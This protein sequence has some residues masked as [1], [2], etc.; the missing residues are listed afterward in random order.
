MSKRLYNIAI[1]GESGT[2]KTTSLENLDPTKTLIVSPYKADLPFEGWEEDYQPLSIAKGTG[3][4]VKTNNISEIGQILKYVIAKRPEIDTIVIDDLT[5]FQTKVVTST[6]FRSRKQGNEAFAKWQDFAADMKDNLLPEDIKDLDRDL[7]VIHVYH[8][9]KNDSGEQEIKVVGKMLKEKIDL[10]SYYNYVL[11][12][13]VMPH[14]PN[15]KFSERYKF[16]VNND[17][18]HLA[19]T[20]KGL[21]DELYIPND[22]N[23]VLN[24]IKEYRTTKKHK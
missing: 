17:G 22:L 16:V 23:A 6:E 19:K 24:R 14:D 18:S 4:L 11:Y 2:G 10:P 15:Q 9:E 21:Y 1:V 20:P 12:T 5:H 8:A 3:N 7:Y 13:T